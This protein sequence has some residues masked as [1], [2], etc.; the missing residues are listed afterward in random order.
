[1]TTNF[2]FFKKKFP[3]SGKAGFWFE[4]LN[5]TVMEEVPEPGEGSVLVP[6]VQQLDLLPDDVL[7]LRA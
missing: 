5:S 7:G 2:F 6:L 4:D 3:S 1:M